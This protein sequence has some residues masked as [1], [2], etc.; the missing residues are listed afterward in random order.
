MERL[1]QHGC[2]VAT[3]TT[4]Q[5][6][7]LIHISFRMYHPKRACGP[8]TMTWFREQ[9]QWSVSPVLCQHRLPNGKH[10]P[11]TETQDPYPG[12]VFLLALLVSCYVPFTNSTSVLSKVVD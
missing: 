3:L 8:V 10:L 9:V 7:S 6:R 5:D 2:C 1:V 4:K 12:E 11:N